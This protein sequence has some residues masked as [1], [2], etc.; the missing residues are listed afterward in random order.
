LWRA[1]DMMA[2]I[3]RPYDDYQKEMERPVSRT[4]IARARVDSLGVHS[5]VSDEV[6]I[7][8]DARR[9]FV[10]LLQ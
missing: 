6:A 7:G 5:T 10:G 3:E 4:G 9:G 8:P 2:K 1:I